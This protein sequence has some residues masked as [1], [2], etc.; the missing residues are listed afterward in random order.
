MKNRIL[1][2]TVL[3]LAIAGPA[4]AQGSPQA[5]HG[6]FVAAH[7]GE[8]GFAGMKLEDAIESRVTTG[9][10]Y[11]AEATTEF[12]NV[13]GDG[14]RIARKSTTR[15]FRDGEGRTR[16][17]ELGT[18]DTA[19]SISIHDPVAKTTFVLD[20]ATKTARKSEVRFFVSPDA[21]NVMVFS[22]KVAPD[23]HAVARKVTEQKETRT[24]RAITMPD[25]PVAGGRVHHPYSRV[26]G[27]ANTKVESLGRQTIEGVAAEG[28]RTTMIIPPGEIG[29]Q[30]EIKV[31]SEEWF[32]PDLQV[33]VMT[34]YSDPRSGETTYRLTNIIRAEPGAGM[35]D[36]PPDYTIEPSN[37]R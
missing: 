9:Q 12:V 19:E 23:A 10:P 21:R 32:S 1:I 34:R 3:G 26:S 8:Q 30:L 6:V 11:S 4:A 2:A 14:N 5:R 33:L 37:F 35:F 31:V 17:E 18:G 28:T 20:P 16:R 24:V 13:L 22:T 29:N 15:I 7:P 27:S 36:V 25:V